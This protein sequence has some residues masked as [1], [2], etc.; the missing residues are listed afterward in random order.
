VVVCVCCSRAIVKN[1]D[2]LPSTPVWQLLVDDFWGT[3]LRH[4]GSH[5]SYRPLCVLTFRLNYLLSA[6]EPFTYHLTNVLLH[7]AV[8]GLYVL[9]VRKA[10]VGC[11]VE[12]RLMSGLVFAVHPVHT[13]AVAGVVGR[14]DVLACLFFLLAIRLYIDYCHAR[15]PPAS[16]S[17]HRQFCSATLTVSTLIDFAPFPSGAAYRGTQPNYCVTFAESEPYCH[18][19]LFVWMSVSHSA[20]YSL[21][22]LIYHNQIWSACICL[23]SDLCKPFW[24]PY[25][26]Y[27]RCQ[28]EKYATANVT[29]RAV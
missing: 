13:E 1:P 21:P 15:Q 10:V 2:V 16:N 11:R 24:I 4:S 23:S 19:I 7:A 20:T 5:K 18:S 26:P 28:R 12:V 29:H 14:A 9:T 17:R 3:R 8:T 22:R 6:L 25:L 27:F